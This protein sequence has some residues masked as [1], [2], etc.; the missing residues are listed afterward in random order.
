MASR[1]PICRRSLEKS[2]PRVCSRFIAAALRSALCLAKCDPAAG[3]AM[4]R[5]Q[6]LDGVIPSGKLF[7]QLPKA[8]IIRALKERTACLG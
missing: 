7:M 5:Y 1:W 8:G 2:Y 4:K 3:L 6:T